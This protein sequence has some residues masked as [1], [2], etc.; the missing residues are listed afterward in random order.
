MVADKKV[1]DIVEGF[2]Q[3]LKKN[4]SLSLL[5]EILTELNRRAEEVGTLATV[6]SSQVLDKVQE[7][8]ITN[9]IKSNFGIGHILF[10]TDN[11]LIGGIKVKIG[12][13]VLDL[14]LQSKLNNLT[15][16]I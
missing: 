2:W 16:A 6:F 14:S 11:T 8:K 9:I 15:K 3:Y 5:P 13:D 7:E 1:K 4:E 12:D 10:K